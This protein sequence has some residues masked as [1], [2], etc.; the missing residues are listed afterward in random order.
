[1]SKPCAL[2]LKRLD[3]HNLIPLLVRG[4]HHRHDFLERKQRHDHGGE[5]D[6]GEGFDPGHHAENPRRPQ[7]DTVGLSGIVRL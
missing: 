3:A 7:G 6:D 1:M 5:E 2:H 4:Q